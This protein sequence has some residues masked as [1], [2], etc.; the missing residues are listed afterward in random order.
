MTIDTFLL[1]RFPLFRKFAVIIAAFWIISAT[2][3]AQAQTGCQTG[4]DVLANAYVRSNP[5]YALY[6]GN[7]ESYIAENRMH[8][9]E[10]GDAI[11]C[12]RAMSAAL[13][14]GSIRSYDPTALRR[15]QELNSQLGS[16]G[17]SP[18]P[19]QASPSAMF[20]EMGQQMAWLAKV[21]PAASRGNYQPLRTPVTDTQRM[22]AFATQMLQSLLQDPSVRQTFVQME[23]LF[24]EAAQMEYK[25][26]MAIAAGLSQ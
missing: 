7:L 3:C 15:Q 25:Q 1:H 23:P 24:R 21:L 14:R 22:K 19:A 13:F 8:F 5:M 20:Y 11:R 4:A 10:N 12:A 6:F 17:I 18:G 16:M 26:L 2:A 9:A